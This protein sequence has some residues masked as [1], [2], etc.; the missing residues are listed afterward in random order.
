MI[1]VVL[2]TVNL[3]YF[4]ELIA[5]IADVAAESGSPLFIPNKL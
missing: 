3:P 1:G 4:A 2:P 5:G